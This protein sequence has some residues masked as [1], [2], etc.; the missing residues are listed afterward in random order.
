MH[1]LL[2]R[3]E[4][5]KAALGDRNWAIEIQTRDHPNANLLVDPKSSPD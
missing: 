1:C 2:A 4:K 5:S 3:E